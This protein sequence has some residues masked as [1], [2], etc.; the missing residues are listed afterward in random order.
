MEFS[1]T[2]LRG[3]KKPK[4]MWISSI[5]KVLISEIVVDVSIAGQKHLANASKMMI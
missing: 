4:L 1:R 2:L 5:P 3:C